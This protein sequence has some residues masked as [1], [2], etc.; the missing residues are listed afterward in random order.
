[1]DRTVSHSQAMD[2]IV[3]HSQ[4]MDRI[5]SHSQA[6][7]R[8]VSHKVENHIYKP[9]VKVLSQ[10]LLKASMIHRLARQCVNHRHW[11]KF[12]KNKNDRDIKFMTK[13]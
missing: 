3:S 4:A 13:L 2:R 1:M 5:V 10:S 11:R 9:H 12:V 7:D 8:I 6:M